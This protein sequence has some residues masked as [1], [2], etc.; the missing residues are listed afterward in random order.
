MAVWLSLIKCSKPDSHQTHVRLSMC[1]FKASAG[2][3]MFPKIYYIFK[4]FENVIIKKYYHISRSSHTAINVE[5]KKRNK[6][7]NKTQKTKHNN[8]TKTRFSQ[9][10]RLETLA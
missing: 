4:S 7:T 2:N 8:A 6:Q 3:V 10:F 5:A 1:G 9:P